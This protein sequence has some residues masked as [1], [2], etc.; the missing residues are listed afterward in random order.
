[1]AGDKGEVQVKV[2][3]YGDDKTGAEVARGEERVGQEGRKEYVQPVDPRREASSM[4]RVGGQVSGASTNRRRR[5][6]RMQHRRSGGN[7]SGIGVV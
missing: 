1:M 3:M 6:G 5:C 7:A 2:D 4:G